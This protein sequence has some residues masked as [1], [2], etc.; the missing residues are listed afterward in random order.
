M[1][2]SEMMISLGTPFIR[3]RPLISMIAV[4]F[5]QAAPMVFLIRSAVVSPTEQA[6]STDVADHGVVHLVP[7]DTVEE[8]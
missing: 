6:G 7:A 8:A 3:S 2:R 4:P 1:L 5:G